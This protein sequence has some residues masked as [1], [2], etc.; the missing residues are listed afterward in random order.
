MNS[1]MPPCIGS[2]IAKATAAAALIAI[3]ALSAPTHAVATPTRLNA[4]D[5]AI[6]ATKASFQTNDTN[7]STSPDGAR[8]T[9]VRLSVS[10]EGRPGDDDDDDDDYTYYY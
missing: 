7:I 9:Q 2:T 4:P 6:D 1:T 8:C 5:Y 10:Y 3:S